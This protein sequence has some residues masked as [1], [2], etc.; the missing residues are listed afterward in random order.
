MEEFN[1]L[2]S[3]NSLSYLPIK[4]WWQRITAPWARCQS[5][6]ILEQYNLGVR[7][8]DIRVRIGVRG[9]LQFC[10]N[11]TVFDLTVEEFFNMVK[12]IPGKCYF[13]VLLDER[14]KPK[15]PNLDK[16]EFLEFCK[17]LEEID[18]DKV[19]VSKVI[20]WDW[21]EL[22]ENPLVKSIGGKYA[23]VSNTFYKYLPPKWYAKKHNPK[24]KPLL[25]NSEGDIKCV[26]FDYIQ[27]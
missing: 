11:I 23:S 27:I 14:T 20:F 10:H 21:E 25:K 13:R 1:C 4:N 8:F 5:L 15:F 9:E 19:I 2:G 16:A 17:A 26:M 12:S 7:L 6:N 3:H 18:P 22:Q 24:W